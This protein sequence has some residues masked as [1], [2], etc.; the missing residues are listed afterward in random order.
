MTSR[1]V[2]DPAAAGDEHDA[3][4]IDAHADGTG[5]AFDTLADLERFLQL[6]LLPGCP[7]PVRVRD[8][9]TARRAMPARLV[10]ATHNPA[11]VAEAHAFLVSID[12]E[13][14]DA[15]TVGAPQP[16]ETGAS[17]FE[18]AR[19]KAEAAANSTGLPALAND[20]GLAITQL[21]GQPGIHTKHW[22]DPDGSA[23]QISA[24]INDM[25]GDT[26][27][28]SATAVCALVLAWPDGEVRHYQALVPGTFVHPPR[29]NNGFGFDT[30]FMPTGGTMT[31]A[32]ISMALKQTIGSQA[33]AFAHLCADLAGSG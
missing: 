20:S 22:L 17:F 23:I 31:Y 13:S 29:G 19:I 27:D 21:D 33:H 11:K 14:R 24:R 1:L 26:P 7:R 32:Q 18:N 8:R 28:R 25:L 10:L 9:A 3:L 5:P 15:G 12:V 2:S 30:V 16:E 4:A 6:D